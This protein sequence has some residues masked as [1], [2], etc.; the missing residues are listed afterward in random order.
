MASAT[1]AVDLT[2]LVGQASASGRLEW[3]LIALFLLVLGFVLLAIELLIIPGF[4]FVGIA[5]CLSI[6]GGGLMAWVKLGAGWGIATIAAGAA[7]S[8]GMIYLLP[9]TRA[10]RRLVLSANQQGMRVG[11]AELAALVGRDA[12]AETPLRPSGA[13]S[14][15]GERLDAITDGIFVERGSKVRIVAVRG[16]RVV[17]EPTS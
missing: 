15:D 3:A 12:L 9:R 7:V 17:V 8:I 2:G 10:G 11:S 14:L 4:G 6:L 1:W 13:V 16:V 5:G